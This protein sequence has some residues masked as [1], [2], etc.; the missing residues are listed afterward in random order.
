MSPVSAVKWGVSTF[1]LRSSFV[2][3]HLEIENFVATHVRKLRV[4]LRSSVLRVSYDL[5]KD[6][7]RQVPGTRY[8]VG[9]LI[10]WVRRRSWELTLEISSPRGLRM[11][12]RARL[13]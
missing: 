6:I 7:S 10:H 4:V 2:E 5:M 8:V 11:I 13:Y 12:R 1:I 3:S 9:R